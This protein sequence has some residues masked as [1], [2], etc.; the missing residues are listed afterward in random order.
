[1]PE[2]GADDAGLVRGEDRDALRR[3]LAVLPPRQR[4]V[5]VLRY[6]EDLPDTTIAMLLGCSPGTVRSH[7]SRGLAA[8]RPLLTSQDSASTR[9]GDAHVG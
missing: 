6:L 5:L 2:A 8:L 1:V 9:E 7:A 3:A 4:A